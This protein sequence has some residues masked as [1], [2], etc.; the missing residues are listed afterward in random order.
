[1]LQPL[2]FDGGRLDRIGCATGQTIVKG[3]ALVDNGNGY[4]VP[5]T[6]STAVDIEYIAWETVTTTADGQL[7]QVYRVAG[8][9]QILADTDNAP[10][11][12]DVHTLADLASVNTINPDASTNDLFYIEKID[13]AV[14][15]K[16][17]IGHFIEVNNT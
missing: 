13:G 12:T 5:A 4:L 2:R 10:A 3:D 15:N 16:R 14:A 17:V 6:S 1:M 8:G 7:V 11:Q 9:V